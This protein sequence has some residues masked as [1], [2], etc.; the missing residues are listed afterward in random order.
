MLP[1]DELPRPGTTGTLKLTQ[2][3]KVVKVPIAGQPGLY[4]TGLL[5]VVPAPTGPLPPPAVDSKNTAVKSPFDK[6]FRMLALIAAV[7]VIL[8]GSSLFWLIHAH[9]QQ[10]IQSHVATPIPNAHATAIA[11]ATATADANIILIDSLKENIHNW[12]ISTS[13]TASKLY[14]FKDGAYHITD[15]DSV[16]S[17]IALLP[18]S[19]ALPGS[20]VYT[21]SLEEIKGNDTS[22]N[23]QFGMI[24]RFS[25]HQ[26]NG[27]TVT[28]FY[29]FEVANIKRGEYQFWKYDNSV[30][31]DVRAWTKIW[32][33]PFGSEF[34]AGHATG[35]NV[36]R[37][38]AKGPRFTFMVNGKQV[39]TA[40]DSSLSSGQIGMLVNLR[41]TEV[42][43]SNLVLAYN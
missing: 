29:A 33:R 43:F 18:L 13:A 2:P 5:P 16:S 14:V 24:L 12:P 28:T 25:T 21:L 32:S 20:F 23:N 6:H 7:L 17:A 27:K 1:P 15:N 30:Y 11:Q 26:K 40:Q 4:M 9:T 41:G 31:S 8:L 3:V 22:V 37:V 35:Y 36:F 34:H 42:A 39:G 10:A 38:A 19:T